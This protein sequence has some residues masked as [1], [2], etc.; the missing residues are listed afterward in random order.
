M[1]RWKWLLVLHF[2]LWK[3]LAGNGPS[4]HLE[5]RKITQKSV[6]W[7]NKNCF[8]SLMWSTFLLLPPQR[9]VCLASLC[10][11]LFH[12]QAGKS[13][14]NQPKYCRSEVD[15]FLLIAF[16]LALLL[17]PLLFFSFLLAEVAPPPKP[18]LSCSLNFI[19]KRKNGGDI[20]NVLC[21]SEL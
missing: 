21:L 18:R 1:E 10:E 13:V 19:Y 20:L 4:E 15:I 16:L 3:P 14:Q 17:L 6:L 7:D 5:R 8:K 12:S 9:N 2:F 11:T